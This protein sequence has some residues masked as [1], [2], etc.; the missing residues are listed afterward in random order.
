MPVLDATIDAEPTYTERQLRVSDLSTQARAFKPALQHIVKSQ[1]DKWPT[2]APMQ[3]NLLEGQDDGQVQGSS[4]ENQS[5]IVPA[6]S[7]DRT[8]EGAATASSGAAIDSNEPVVTAMPP[9]DRLERA[10]L[11]LTNPT[12]PRTALGGEE[13]CGTPPQI[14]HSQLSFGIQTI[15]NICALAPR[16]QR[17]DKKHAPKK[18]DCKNVSDSSIPS[19]KCPQSP[20][21]EEPPQETLRTDLGVL[22]KFRGCLR[23]PGASLAGGWK[24]GLE[25]GERQGEGKKTPI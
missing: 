24:W 15:G 23:G 13:G 20:F 2:S 19:P 4:D 16:N 25:N 9:S 3:S 11:D 22:S 17:K 21:R 10:R 6:V 5:Q 8:V 14:R 1:K 12:A 7:V 18:F